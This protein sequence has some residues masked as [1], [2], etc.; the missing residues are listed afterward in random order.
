VTALASG[1]GRGL[2]LLERRDGHLALTSRGFD[3]YHDLERRVTYRFIEPLWAEMVAEHRGEATA[4][5][6]VE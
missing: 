6:S 3:R 4:V 1:L 2:G 5:P